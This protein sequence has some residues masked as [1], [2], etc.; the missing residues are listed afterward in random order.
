M[1]DELVSWAEINLDAFEANL[2]AIRRHVGPRVEVMAVVKANAYGHGAVTLAPVALRAGATRLAVHRAIEGIE[3]RRS[4][5]QAPIL[6]LGYTPPAAAGQVVRWNLTPSVITTDF[7]QA[8]SSQ[9]ASA[10][11]EIPV[12]IK[13]DTGMHRYGVMPEE[14]LDFAR[15]VQALPNL[16]LEGLFTH[17]ATA[18]ALDQ[19][20]VLKQLQTFS[21]VLATLEQ[22]QLHIPVVHAANSA[23]IMRLPQAHFNLVRPGISLYGLP[24]SVEWDPPFELRPILTLKSRVA[25]LHPL[26]PG[27]A[28]GY[29]RTFV[30]SHAMRVALV[31]M[32]YGDGFHRVLSNKGCVLVGGRRAPILGR[33]SMDQI[34]VDVTDI[35]GVNQDDEVVIIGRQGEES[36][37]AT[38]VAALAGTVNYEVTTGLLPRVTRIYLRGG[39]EVARIGLGE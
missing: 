17:F 10:G 32:G 30:A 35:P 26:P 29:G 2:Q 18:D 15:A 33:V 36:I 38:E 13:V 23:T 24:P 34:V 37:T 25:R 4:G 28:V 9:A 27:G 19:T 22:A 14:V 12:H 3:L 11:A 8:L 5:I 39:R 1:P 21:E 7:A 31:V 6:L 20:H 16:R